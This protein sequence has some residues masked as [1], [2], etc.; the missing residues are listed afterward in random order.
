MGKKGLEPSRLA[1]PAPKAGV[2][3]NSTTCPRQSRGVGFRK[4]VL[5]AYFSL[6]SSLPLNFAKYCNAEFV[7]IAK[8]NRGILLYFPVKDHLGVAV[9][10][11]DCNFAA[12]KSR[13]FLAPRI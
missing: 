8:N 1:A 11:G 12:L 6:S 9:I 7:K 5:L 3:T 2:S 4:R 10:L 13:I